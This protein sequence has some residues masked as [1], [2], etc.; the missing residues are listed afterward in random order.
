MGEIIEIL[1]REYWSK[2]DAFIVPLTGLVK[3]LKYVSSS[4]MFWDEYSIENYQLTMKFFHK[5]SEIFNRYCKDYLFPVLTKE[6]YLIET[7]DCIDGDIF[8]LD[9]SEWGEDI[10]MLLAAKYSK[11]SNEAKLIIKRYHKLKNGDIPIQYYAVLHPFN[12]VDPLLGKMSSIDYV[13]K[14][15]EFDAGELRKIGEL[16]TR[17]E[18]DKETLLEPCDKLKHEL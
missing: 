1:K 15:Y 12:E 2:S 18:K 7:F 8:I 10:D 14:N 11:M 6:N 4:Y 3:N 5:N 16:G 13:A 9:M 17:Y